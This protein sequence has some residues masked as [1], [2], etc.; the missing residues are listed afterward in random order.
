MGQRGRPRYPDLLTPREQDVLALI[1]EGLTN[2]QIAARLGIGFET[3]KT[4]VSQIISKLGVS[5]REEAA[6]WRE[7]E[8]RRWWSTIPVLLKAA[9]VT[10]A[11][12][13]LA[14]L[15]LLAAE[16]FGSG[17]SEPSNV[18][19]TGE[20]TVTPARPSA[21]SAASGTAGATPAASPALSTPTVATIEVPPTATATAPPAPTSTIP[22]G[23]LPI[24]GYEVRVVNSDGSGVQTLAVGRSPVWEP[25]GDNVAYI[26]QTTP[27]QV[28]GAA[29]LEG[30]HWV[31]Q[32]GVDG[33]P[34]TEIAS[35]QWSDI[36]FRCNVTGRGFG[37][38]A[39]GTN[40]IT[41]NLD[42][43]GGTL[44]DLL[45]GATYPIENGCSSLWLPDGR[46]L[47]TAL[48][49]ESRSEFCIY[50]YNGGSSI[51]LTDGL[52]GDASPDG[53]RLA[54]ARNG[55]LWVRDMESGAEELLQNL[56]GLGSV[57]WSPDGREILFLEEQEEPLSGRIEAYDIQSGTTRQI[58]EGLSPRW[59]PDGSYISYTSVASDGCPT[60]HVIDAANLHERFALSNANDLEWSGDGSRLA[61]TEYVNDRCQS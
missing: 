59:S 56:T 26:A 57:E 50:A 2:E 38:S 46:L 36:L 44:F 17:G 11:V 14:G 30:T 27:V 4:H 34:D 3:A 13:V 9:L 1:R 20:P 41:W 16:F 23:R 6:Q 25:G 43:L 18:L 40:F 39:D 21:S 48:C 53:R 52:I 51:R 24:S 8:R 49:E 29:Y 58:A 5:T 31:H 32:V 47:I 55:G 15:V 28:D 35:Y 54:F 60:G 37:W 42:D 61:Y 12:A 7:G 45:T 10:A 22:T 33:A 19:A